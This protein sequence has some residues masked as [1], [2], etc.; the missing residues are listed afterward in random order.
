[1]FRSEHTENRFIDAFERIATALERQPVTPPV[2]IQTK[3]FN[4]IR[5]YVIAGEMIQ[6]IKLFRELTGASL[7]DAKDQVDALRNALRF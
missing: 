5:N 7:K 3:T 1:M 6:A 4:D 2:Q